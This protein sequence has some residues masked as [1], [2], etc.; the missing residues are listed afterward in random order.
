MKLNH[1]LTLKI[2][3]MSNLEIS[4]LMGTEKRTQYFVHS[5]GNCFNFWGNSRKNLKV[6]VYN[7]LCRNGLQYNGGN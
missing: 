4:I 3:Y 7:G 1:F 5:L 6:S 2:Y